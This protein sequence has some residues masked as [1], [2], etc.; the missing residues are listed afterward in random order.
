MTLI[1]ELLSKDVRDKLVKEI[2]EEIANEIEA[3]PVESSL[4][5]AVGMKLQATMIARG[6]K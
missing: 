6:N 2:R 5:N 3:I 1:Y 4:T